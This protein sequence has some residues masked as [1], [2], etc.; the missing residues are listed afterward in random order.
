MYRQV[1]TRRKESRRECGG[2]VWVHVDT[3]VYAVCAGQLKENRV[4]DDHMCVTGEIDVLTRM[5]SADR[6]E[7]RMGPGCSWLAPA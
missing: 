5:Y 2:V 6:S 7:C 4:L 3:C 1:P